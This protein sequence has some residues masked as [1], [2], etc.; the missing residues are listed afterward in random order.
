[1]S[2]DQSQ[3]KY[4]NRSTR[5]CFTVKTDVRWKAWGKTLLNIQFWDPKGG[6]GNHTSSSE[7]NLEE[8][9]ITHVLSLI[10]ICVLAHGNMRWRT[11]TCEFGWMCWAAASEEQI[12]FLSFHNIDG[13]GRMESE[14]QRD[15]EG[16]GE[17]NRGGARAE[18]IRLEMVMTHFQSPICSASCLCCCVCTCYVL[19]AL[20]VKYTYEMANAN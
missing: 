1:M 5:G 17:R 8:A 6:G 9:T 2:E 19:P 12:N 7:I 20:L 3:V 18:V 15:R 14:R 10:T 13:E 16:R 4:Q 11:E